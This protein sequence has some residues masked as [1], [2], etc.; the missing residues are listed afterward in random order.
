[1]FVLE[2]A[3]GW[4]VCCAPED[5]TRLVAGLQEDCSQDVELHALWKAVAS[6]LLPDARRKDSEGEAA[7][8]LRYDVRSI[9]AMNHGKKS[10]VMC[11]GLLSWAIVGVGVNVFR[12]AVMA[13][14]GGWH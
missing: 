1:M 9:L 2:N 6:R 7:D 13:G 12:G 14:D 3:R 4:S 11:S 5:F 10:M 8:V